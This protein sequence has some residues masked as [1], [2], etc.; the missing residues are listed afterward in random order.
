MGAREPRRRAPARERPRG[1][2][3]ALRRAPARSMSPSPASVLPADAR[4]AAGAAA[5]WIAAMRAVPGS[6]HGLG[7]VGVG[8][9]PGV[10]RAAAPPGSWT[11]VRASNPGEV[12]ERSFRVV[13]REVAGLHP[14]LMP[15]RRGRDRRRRRRG[16]EDHR[17]GRAGPARA[18]E[19]RRAPRR[20]GR[21]RRRR[22]RRRPRRVLRRHLPARGPR[23]PGPDD[24]RRPGRLGLRRQDRGRPARGQEL[25][26]RL[27]PAA[28]RARRPRDARA[29]SPPRRWRPASPRS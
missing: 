10:R 23:G 25:R 29:P 9:L 1:V 19:G 21:R 12:P 15:E 6:A 18:G 11:A 20:P 17:R 14:G 3:A 13:D 4:E 16:D 7:R 5:H 8:L 26:R 2:L 24:A 28:R 27:P 22:G